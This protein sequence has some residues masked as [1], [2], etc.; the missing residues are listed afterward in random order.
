[1]RA[2]ALIAVIALAACSPANDP[3][4]QDGAAPGD[5]ATE[6][7]YV[8]PTGSNEIFHQATGA[9]PGHELIV[10]DLNLPSD[11]V[12]EPHYHPW[13]EYLYVIAGTAV[14]DIEGAEGRTLQAGE[15]FIIPRETVHTPRA[16]P[17]GVRAIVIRVHKEG[18]P[19][20]V[21]ANK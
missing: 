12:G 9:A 16:G 19:V 1:M 18:D 15:R 11:A 3:G 10:A 4:I 5:E 20:M 17:K 21:P 7:A 14:L 13:E 6:P 8:P 2:G